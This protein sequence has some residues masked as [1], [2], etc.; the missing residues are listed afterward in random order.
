[1]NVATT[2]VRSGVVA[3]QIPAST[4]EIRVSPS[5]SRRK[6]IELPNRAITNR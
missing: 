6:G 2:S 1:M 4:D 3:F 5:A